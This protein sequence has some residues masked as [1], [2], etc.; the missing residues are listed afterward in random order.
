M[1]QCRGHSDSY[2]VQIQKHVCD[3]EPPCPLSSPLHVSMKTKPFAHDHNG[4]CL[5]ECAPLPPSLL[6][7]IL[8]PSL[9]GLFLTGSKRQSLP[10]ALLSTWG[11][12][13]QGTEQVLYF[14]D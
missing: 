5:A 3:L 7:T 9:Y 2:T 11:M 14:G 12:G 13:H 4:L 1:L 8:A 6:N 10:P